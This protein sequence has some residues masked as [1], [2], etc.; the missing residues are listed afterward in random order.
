[1]T[2]QLSYDDHCTE[3]IRQ[4]DL[5]RTLIND[6]GGAEGVDLTT[7]VPSCPGWN[8]GQLVR[9]LGGA[10]RWTEEI[11]RNRAPE[12]PPDDQVRD[13]SA[14]ADED[15]AVVDP[16]LAEGAA[17]LADTLR[18]AGPDAQLWSPIAGSGGTA[19]FFARRMAHETVIHRADATLA[20]GADFTVDEDV[21]IDAVDEWMELGSL[22]QMF[23]F[24][25]GRR[26]L[27][28]PNRTLHFHATDTPPEAAAEWLVDLTGDAIA[29]RR[30]HE[31]ATVAVRGPLTDLLLLVYRRRSPASARLEILGDASLLRFWLDRVSFG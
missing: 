29:W 5:L 1:M 12:P 10:Q 30:A 21:A 7:P 16:W 6:A 26:E 17:Q 24:Y 4:T 27:L 19:R 22:P 8:V 3:I 2:R 31:K 18:A 20:V 23:D 14:Y 11:V 15:P 13:L 25:P 28:G 9:H